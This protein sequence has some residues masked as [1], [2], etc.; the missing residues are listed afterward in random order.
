MDYFAALIVVAAGVALFVRLVRKAKRDE[1]A[2]RD[3]ISQYTNPSTASPSPIR[4][5]PDRTAKPSRA[6][7]TGWSLG[8]VSFTY[9]DSNGDVTSRTI[10]VHSVTPTYLKGECHD[11]NA[12]RTFRIDRM[13]GEVV[14]LESGELIR[15]RSLARHFA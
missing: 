12:E 2:Q 15:P 9:Q 1:Q 14:D 10:T 7:R 6:M 5:T 11:R 3:M 13:I 8:T 4:R